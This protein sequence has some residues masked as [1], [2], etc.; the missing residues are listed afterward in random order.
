MRQ[1]FGRTTTATVG[2]AV[3]A[4][5]LAATGSAAVPRLTFHQAHAAVRGFNRADHP[6]HEWVGGCVREARRRIVCRDVERNV[7]TDWTADGQPLV[8]TRLVSQM[9]VV[10]GEHG[11]RVFG[12]VTDFAGTAG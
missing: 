7:A 2:A 8:M 1:C 5:A 3:A 9:T 4:L 10:R 11:L 6:S 12:I